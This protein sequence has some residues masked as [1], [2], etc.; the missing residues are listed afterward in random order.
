MPITKSPY[1]AINAAVGGAIA[2]EYLRYAK[3]A[4]GAGDKFFR[5]VAFRFEMRKVLKK[6]LADSK[7]RFCKASLALAR[8]LR[9]MATKYS[10]C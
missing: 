7:P 6:I 9:R 2:K 8:A 1:N 3:G 10:A 5:S 4:K